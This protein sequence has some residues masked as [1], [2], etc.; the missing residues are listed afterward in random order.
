LLELDLLKNI[1]ENNTF[2]VVES[3]LERK[4]PETHAITSRNAV[5]DGLARRKLHDHS[6][7]LLSQDWFD[8]AAIRHIMT[9]CSIHISSHTDDSKML[10]S[11]TYRARPEQRL[12]LARRGEI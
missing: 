3:L 6:Q 12:S 4:E 11:N 8:E 9:A 2:R 7:Y 1:V 5:T 10:T